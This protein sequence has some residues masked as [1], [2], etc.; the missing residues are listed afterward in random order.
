MKRK[1][2][3][4]GVDGVT[5]TLPITWVRDHHLKPGDEIEVDEEKNVLS[6]HPFFKKKEKKRKDITINV[7]NFNIQRCIFA[8]LYRFG[9][10][11]I[12]VQYD[13]P[14]V[15]VVLQKTVDSFYGF[16][17]FDVDQK[18][19]IIKSVFHEEATE[20]E[21]HIRRAI[22]TIKTMQSIIIEDIRKKEYNS[23][24]QLQQFRNNV[25]KQRD[26][27]ARIIL[28]QKLFDEKHYPNE[29]IAFNLWNIARNYDHI[30]TACCSMK[31]ISG[32]TLAFLEKTNTFFSTFF[33]AMKKHDLVSI[34]KQYRQLSNEARAL[35]L[36]KKEASLVLAH[37]LNIL[38]FIQSSNASVM[39][40]QS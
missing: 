15:A 40:L 25:L 36:D 19:C 10:D 38:M 39:L 28:Q 5:I 8:G 11:E 7:A 31:K 2:I 20:I 21:G 34:H 6:I 35:M 9:Y 29:L 16:E 3:K 1:L 17:M 13:S 33:D 37:C 30:Y 18:S 27:I 14:E 32:T 23:S 4:Q 22:H 26:I 12:H 24:E